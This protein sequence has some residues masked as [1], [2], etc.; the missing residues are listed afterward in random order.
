[1]ADSLVLGNTIELLGGPDGSPSTIP[2]CAGAV[3][4]L[5]TGTGMDLG[6]PQPTT[7]F[8]AS[9][10][11]DGERPFGR[12]ASNRTITL[13]V[14]IRAPSG[15]PSARSRLLAAAREV[16]EQ[17]IDQDR[18]TLTWT[19]DGGL[20]LVIDCFRA[21]PSKPAY[22]PLREPLGVMTVTLTIPA[23]PY[24]RSDVQTRV[25]FAAPVPASPPPPPAPVVLDTFS[26][27]S[28]TR[29]YQSS[30]CV[31]GPW[32]LC[33]DPDDA[34]VGDPGG[35]STAFT[36]SAGL[37]VTQNLTGL[38][39]LQMF[40]GF[41]S[42][43]Y[44]CLEYHG[45]THGVA[46]TVTLT[47]SSARV[48]SM[49]KTGLRLPVSPTWGIPSF[50]R[51]TLPIPQGSAA[52]DYTSVVAYSVTITNRRGPDRLSWVTAYVDALTAYPPSVQAQPVT[53]GSVYTLHGVQGTARAACSMT[54]QQGPS[55]GTPSAL[56]T[57]GVGT[58]TVPANTAWL[59][60]ECI[61]GGGP[62]ATRTT[63]GVGGGG[64]GAEY[65][66]EDVFPC[67]PGDVIPYNVAASAAP[68]SDGPSTVFG[69]G[70]SSSLV[71]IANGGQAAAQNSTAGGA[72]GDGSGN[73]VHYPGGTGRT[74]SGSVGG[75]GASSGGS[76][77]PGLAPTGTA[78]DTRTSTGAGTWTCPA[79]VT[80]VLVECWGPGGSGAAGGS[81]TNGAGGGGGEYCSAT[82]A[83]TPANVYN[84]S[85]GAG[86]AAVTGNNVNGNPGAATTWFTGDAGATVTAHPGGAGQAR[87]SSGGGGA[88]GTGGGGAATVHRDG[89]A[90]GSAMPYSGGGGSS[91]GPGAAGNAGDGYGD[92]GAA[93]T[94][95]GKGGAGSGAT[96]S[97]GGA[98]TQPGG[99]GG[100][101]W[102]AVT[103][104]KGGDGKI[105]LTYPG[106]A[107]TNNGA[108]AVT[109]GGAGGNGGASPGSAGAAGSQPGGAGGGA[110]SGGTAVAGG[111]GAAGKI[112]V[113]PYASAAFSS[114]IAHRPPL[115][116]PRTF[117]PLVSVGGGSDVPN[118]A[119]QYIMPQPVNGVA[120]DFGGT[121]TVLL[122]AA[123]WSGGSGS[124][125]PRTITVTVWQYE[126]P[127]GPATSASTQPVSIAPVQVTN[128]L[129]TAGV[130]TLPT[131]AVAPDN[132]AGYYAVSVTSS[133]T[134][135][136]FYDALFL[137]TM[138][139]TMIVNRS[140]G[141]YVTY[142]ADAPNPDTDLGYLTGSQASRSS[143]ISVLDSA[144]LSGGP[145]HVEPAEGD[146][147]LFVYSADA[148]APSVALSYFPA[149]YF[150]RTA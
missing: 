89:G 66:R 128:G 29:H 112:T 132:T 6:A 113:T 116:A 3:F 70:P 73:A 20:P 121:Y 39:S 31:I 34:R 109:G 74:A 115:G 16:L 15:T 86:G 24:G 41:G 139:Q 13:D 126:Y 65:A 117:Q 46:V 138:G 37:G 21:Q 104:G 75:G 123:S 36:Y 118:G 45:H 11:L 144:V 56:T 54:F 147:L 148:A 96:G 42:R 23:L 82:V 119:S 95:G 8:V 88:G 27:V 25:A 53:R 44:H 17:V 19:R 84:Y 9:L 62:G 127:G 91:A 101:T 124:S 129:V 32:S 77:S 48:L 64:G 106:G 143:A 141:G 108:A 149:W 71:V 78:A 40:L 67:T 131:R 94:D 69:P 68:G 140:S 33:W 85:I 2:E 142:W 150:D 137:D 55:A 80:Q 52:F 50:S 100:G 1:M 51:V 83:V 47:D 22:S 79:G 49:S 72:P 130:L 102:A 145:L 63:A 122:T 81:S 133:N 105:R 12:R 135:D 111:N 120:A 103:S 61:G 134:S 87:G 43:Y 57:A 59:K 107:P 28:S 114:L 98:G 93:P 18:W 90:G 58:Y 35:A 125:T 30:R 7:D 136:R 10:L 4:R 38:T 99:G 92:G 5:A 110:N 76:G 146:N 97:N 60:V 26:S 14:I